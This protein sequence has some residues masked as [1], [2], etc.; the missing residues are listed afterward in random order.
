MVAKG[1][2]RVLVDA[3]ASHGSTPVVQG[4]GLGAIRWNYS[5]GQ[6][7]KRPREVAEPH[8]VLQVSARFC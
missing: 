1:C 2:L 5:Q 4:A 6:E 3:T 8:V 7:G